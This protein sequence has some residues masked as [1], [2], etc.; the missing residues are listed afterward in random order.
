MLTV[1]ACTPDIY[2]RAALLCRID[3]IVAGETAFMDL[4]DMLLAMDAGYVPTIHPN[5]T[6]LRLLGAML[7]SWGYRVWPCVGHIRQFDV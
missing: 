1:S 4:T 3:R 6:G 5:T 2:H 7:R